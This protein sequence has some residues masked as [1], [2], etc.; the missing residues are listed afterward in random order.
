ME[1]ILGFNHPTTKAVLERLHHE[2]C[3]RGESER[4]NTLLEEH[5]RG[6]AVS[7]AT[8]L[9]VAAAER[10]VLALVVLA[11]FVAPAHRRGRVGRTVVAHFKA[12]AEE[13]RA[14]TLEAY[15][16]PEASDAL[17]FFAACGFQEVNTTPSG[18]KG[19]APGSEPAAHSGAAL[20]P[21]AVKELR[22]R[23]R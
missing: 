15:V 20:L 11:I 9:P 5:G 22:M 13:L 6:Q 3:S 12:L 21:A 8:A 1:K 16:A 18:E 19:A 4:A 10:G 7:D 23:L 17:A 14:E 2:L